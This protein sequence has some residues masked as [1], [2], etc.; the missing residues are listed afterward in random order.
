[1]NR[2]LKF[3]FE[4]NFGIEYEFTNTSSSLTRMADLVRSLV[5]DECRVVSY[6]HTRNNYNYWVCKTDRSC[7]TELVSPILHGP[8]ALKKATDI[9]VALHDDDFRINNSCGQH[10]HIEIADF[11]TEQVGI[12]VAYWLKVERFIINGTPAHRRQ[13]SFCSPSTHHFTINPTYKY[14]PELI[15]R[16]F[17]SGRRAIN[18]GN[19]IASENRGTVEFRFGEMTFNPEIVKN[20]VRFLIWLVEMCRILPMPNNLKWF[21]PKEALS[22]FGLW[23]DPSSIIKYQY[24]PAMQSMRKWLLKRLVQYAPPVFEKDIVRCRKMLEELEGVETAQI[25]EQEI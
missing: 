2:L 17:S 10:V 13:N 12:L 22:M 23:E 11:T 14:D 9:L 5:G 15:L 21:S 4:R 8:A 20:R 3:K 16:S 1:M 7:G 24:S 19:W 18:L 6:E 25:A